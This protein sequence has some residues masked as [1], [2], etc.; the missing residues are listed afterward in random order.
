M[1]TES[2]T[3]QNFDDVVFENRHKEYGAY[4]LRRSYHS[5][6]NKGF[7][8]TLLCIGVIA[9]LYTVASYLTGGNIIPKVPVTTECHP[10]PAPE[11]IKRKTENKAIAH[12]KSNHN[13]IPKPTPDPVADEDIVLNDPKPI[14][15]VGDDT[16]A[17]VDFDGDTDGGV[18]VGAGG[19]DVITTTAVTPTVFT[20]VEIMPAY[21]GGVEAMMKFLRKNLHYPSVAR[22]LG[23]EGTVFV[24]FI[25]NSD[26][27]VIQAE[28]LRG[29]SKE[30]DA[31]AKRV[32]GLMPAWS[33]GQ[34]NKTAVMVRMVLPISYKL[35]V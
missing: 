25:I 27:R 13:V 35:D 34:Q 24:S 15:A 26:G 3:Y 2:V 17:A 8:F 14:T 7:S 16:G 29:I 22:R 4:A 1:K 6:V 5:N 21:K 32:I 18:D 19:N 10:G 30:C 23:T 12:T 33:P 11:I 9:A 31:E 28:I 20:T